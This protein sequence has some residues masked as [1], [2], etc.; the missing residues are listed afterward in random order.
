MNKKKKIV[1]VLLLILTFFFIACSTNNKNIIAEREKNIIKDTEITIPNKKEIIE[2]LAS[3]EFEGRF[4]KN[5]GNKLAGK[6]IYDIF[7]SLR[8]D[9]F[10]KTDYYHL[11][12]YKDSEDYNTT[13]RI[14]REAFN[15]VGKISGK[16]NKN[17][18]ILSAHFDHIGIQSGKLIR[19]ALDNASGVS[20]LISL[21]DKLKKE[22]NKNQFDYDIIFAAFNQEEV[23]MYGSKS[24]VSDI[25]GVYD[26]FYN[27]NIDSVGYKDGGNVILNNTFN[28]FQ[29]I[30]NKSNK[31]QL[32]NDN[33]DKLYNEIK[34]YFET[35]N[36]PVSNTSPAY[37]GSDDYS[38]QEKGYTAIGIIEEN[39]K[40]IIHTVNDTPEIID[41]N[42]LESVEKS[43]YNF[44]INS[45]DCL[46]K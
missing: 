44:I 2:K 10:L 43:I 26:K 34:P 41:Y 31:K 27:I 28:Q 16:E 15:I 42:R 1:L 17:A 40:K 22:S 13:I 14:E 20:V 4:I 36:L 9:P 6:Y 33:Y 8:L 24:F 5:N 38:F 3:D 25:T 23:G 39:V 12:T 46:F 18:I 29:K 11:Y 35:N 37:L 30:S 32:N 7:S 45:G 21:A 19:G